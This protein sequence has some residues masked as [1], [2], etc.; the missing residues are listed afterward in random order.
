MYLNQ[1]RL[2]QFEEPVITMRG[3]DERYEPEA[4][5]QGH[6]LGVHNLADYCTND[7]YLFISKK[8]PAVKLTKTWESIQGKIMEEIYFETY[9]LCKSYIYETSLRNLR[10]NVDLRNSIL[11]LVGNKREKITNLESSLRRRPR[12]N[13]IDLF[14]N[15]LEI[16]ADNE[17]SLFSTYM[18]FLI[19]KKLNVNRKT[20]FQSVFNFIFEHPIDGTKVGLGNNLTPDFIFIHKVIGDIKTGKWED[21][22]RVMVAAYAMAYEASEKCDMNCG[23]VLNPV[24]SG[25]R[26]VPLYTN[27]EFFIV[28]DVLRQAFLAKRNQKLKILKE[29]K[30]PDKPPDDSKCKSCGYWDY[31]WG[32]NDS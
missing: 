11:E 27:S 6:T 19:S 2:K 1:S 18:Q 8:M 30:I 22:F 32:E 20:E 5:L 25:S 3:Y 17:F 9:N 16:L 12:A 24:F 7:R 29:E 26:K 21:F 4:E 10:F 31:C 15:K 23:I 14:M 28:S 13:E